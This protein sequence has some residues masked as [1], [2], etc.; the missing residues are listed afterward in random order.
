MQVVHHVGTVKA[1]QE[2]PQ[3]V[4]CATVFVCINKYNVLLCR[5][6]H[7]TNSLQQHID[8]FMPVNTIVH[9]LKPLCV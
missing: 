1:G 8:V 5:T 2:T 9:F 7:S 6:K 3:Q 4:V